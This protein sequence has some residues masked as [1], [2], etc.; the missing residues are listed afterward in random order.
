MTSNLR[1][2]R[3]RAKLTQKQLSELSGVP[4]S[5]IGVIEAEYENRKAVQVNVALPLAKA[6]NTTVEEL[7][8][9]GLA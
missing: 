2:F 9:Q 5:T 3:R 4:T 1:A 6:L 7:F 8:G